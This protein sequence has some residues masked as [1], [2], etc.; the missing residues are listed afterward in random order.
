LTSDETFSSNLRSWK[1]LEQDSNH[2]VFKRGTVLDYFWQKALK[3]NLPVVILIMF[4]SEGN[5]IPESLL[6]GEE[7]LKYLQV[8]LPQGGWLLPPS[9]KFI[10]EDFV[11]TDST[12]I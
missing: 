2:H 9:W 4:C 7:L 6:M 5:N 11:F 10:N 8:P 12:Y 1:K 3:G